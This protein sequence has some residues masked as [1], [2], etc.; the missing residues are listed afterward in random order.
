MSGA[1]T[2]VREWDSNAISKWLKENCDFSK[3]QIKQFKKHD[4]TAKVLLDL[5]EQDVLEIG[6]TVGAKRRFLTQQSEL[7]RENHYNQTG[8]DINSVARN[9]Q[10][11]TVA[12]EFDAEQKKATKIITGNGDNRVNPAQPHDGHHLGRMLSGLQMT[13][14]QSLGIEFLVGLTGTERE[15]PPPNHNDPRHRSIDDL[16]IV[17]GQVAAHIQEMTRIYI[18]GQQ[19]APP[20]E[21]LGNEGCLNDGARTWTVH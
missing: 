12:K 14:N 17:S 2:P 4:I 3:A 20:Q 9:N 18:T 16:G 13:V 10:M 19:A 7:R 5:T 21:K 15:K 1:N 11:N 6:L 8:S